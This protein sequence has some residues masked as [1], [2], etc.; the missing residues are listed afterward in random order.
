MAS[1]AVI[2]ARMRADVKMRSTGRSLMRFPAS[3]ASFTPFS[4]SGT[5]THPVN[6]F[7]EFHSDSP[8]R[9]KINADSSAPPRPHHHQNK[10]PHPT[11]HNPYQR[12]KQNPSKKKNPPEQE[13]CCRNIDS[14][15][16]LGLSRIS[17]LRDVVRWVRNQSKRNRKHTLGKRSSI[18]LRHKLLAT[19][20]NF[21]HHA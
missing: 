10:L 21:R 2:W 13:H 18:R 19:A 12:P 14:D 17:T 8:W 5:S 16:R 20:S 7:L 4:D 9:I 1:M 3:T 11:T 6:R 15:P